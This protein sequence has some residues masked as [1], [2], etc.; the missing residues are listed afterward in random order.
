MAIKENAMA[1]C[2]FCP[3]P[4][5]AELYVSPAMCDKHIMAA[6]IVALR[7]PVVAENIRQIVALYPQI[8]LPA[9]EAVQL[10]QPL[11]SENGGIRI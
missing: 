10:C 5:A 3:A 1:T 2:T 4:A 6:V 11:I 8:G 7:L 9:D